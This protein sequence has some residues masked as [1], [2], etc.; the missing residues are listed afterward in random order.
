MQQ[1]AQ[2]CTQSELV[3]EQ[4]QPRHIIDE[5]GNDLGPVDP[6]WAKNY[7]DCYAQTS[8]Q[9]F[10]CNAIVQ[11][12]A[13]DDQAYATTYRPVVDACFDEPLPPTSVTTI[14]PSATI[15][16]P[17]SDEFAPDGHDID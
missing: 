10:G 2:S 17:A 15:E 11:H 12:Q 7:C 9:M 16:P 4:G 5:V 3:D 14:P 13:L 1:I 8:F 6:T